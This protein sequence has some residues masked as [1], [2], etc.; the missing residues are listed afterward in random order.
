MNCFHNVAGVEFH[1]SDN[2]IDIDEKPM[3][4]DLG[5]VDLDDDLDRQLA[6][7]EEAIMSDTP[8]NSASIP[9][10]NARSA[11]SPADNARSASSPAD[12]ASSASIPADNARSASS[13][14][15]TASSASL[16]DD[17]ASFASTSSRNT[18]SQ[19]RQTKQSPQKFV[20]FQPNGIR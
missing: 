16:P 12:N 7:A 5:D 3:I 10:D 9:A 2:E 6:I 11:S 20:I 4:D 18:R 13:P 19:H 15:V 14:A 17:T 1:I 8:E